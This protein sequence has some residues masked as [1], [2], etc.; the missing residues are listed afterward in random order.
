MSYNIAVV[1]ENCGWRGVIIVNGGELV[2][3]QVC[4]ICECQTLR[5][6]YGAEGLK[7]DNSNEGEK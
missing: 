6:R 4:P 3:R 2:D 7:E 5:K 1:C